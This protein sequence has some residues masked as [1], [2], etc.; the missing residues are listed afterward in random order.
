TDAV[1]RRLAPARRPPRVS[2]RAAARCGRGRSPGAP[3]GSRGPFRPCTGPWRRAPGGA[4]RRSA[5][6]SRL[7]WASRSRPRRVSPHQRSPYVKTTQLRRTPMLHGYSAWIDRSYV[8]EVYRALETINMGHLGEAEYAALRRYGV[9][10][11]ILDR[12]AFPMKVSPFGPAFT[13]AGLE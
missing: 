13:R 11:V 7:G 3:R 6:L 9:R 1:G 5:R 2:R 12:D 4:P 10:Q 8:T